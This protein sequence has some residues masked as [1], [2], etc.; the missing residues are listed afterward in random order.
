MTPS[1]GGRMAKV[2]NT[3]V[4]GRAVCYSVRMFGFTAAA[5]HYV[6]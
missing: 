5:P 1:S 4:A 2:A 6:D 3:A